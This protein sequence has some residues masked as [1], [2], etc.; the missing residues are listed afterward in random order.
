MLKKLG[1][2]ENENQKYKL[3][4]SMKKI[5]KSPKKRKKIKVINRI[6]TTHAIF[7]FNS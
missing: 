1:S 5:T 4:K 7:G 2:V 6:S 3:W